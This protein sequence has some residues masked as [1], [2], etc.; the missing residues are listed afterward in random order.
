MRSGV[1][2]HITFCRMKRHRTILGTQ[3]GTHDA[4]E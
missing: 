3:H 4:E 1:K 2:K